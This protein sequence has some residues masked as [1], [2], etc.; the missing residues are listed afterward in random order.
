MSKTA[1]A[2]LVKF[3]M[4]FIFAGAAFVFMDGNAW[5]RM[6]LV[7]L[8]GT[9]LN[10]LAGDLLVLPAYGNLAASF[11]DGFMAALTAYA[12]DLLVPAFQVSLA[13]L[14]IFALLVI[15]GEYFFHRYLLRSEKV[16]P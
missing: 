10:Y 6:F 13:A 9:A 2:L 5:G 8:A 7:S 4:T 14:G 12:V 11:G 16:A 3:L 15:S 1:G